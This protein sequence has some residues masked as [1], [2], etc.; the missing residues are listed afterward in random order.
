MYARPELFLGG[1]ISHSVAIIIMKPLGRLSYCF[2]TYIVNHF[3]RE[4]LIDVIS[5]VSFK[6]ISKHFASL[7]IVEHGHCYF[8]Q[9][10]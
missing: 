7:I 10:V 5:A 6:T 1:K 9:I 3:F 8:Y 4:A 2:I